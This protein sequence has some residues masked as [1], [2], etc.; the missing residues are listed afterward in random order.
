VPSNGPLP[1]S[2]SN[3]ELLGV[4]ALDLRRATGE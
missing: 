2:N 4:V 1:E 3:D